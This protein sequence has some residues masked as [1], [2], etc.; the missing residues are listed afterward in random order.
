[1]DGGALR[2]EQQFAGA[3]DEGIA[4]PFQRRASNEV[5]QHLQQDRRHARHAVAIQ[6]EPRRFQRR[7]PHDAV[8]EAQEVGEVL[9]RIGIGECGDARRLHHLQRVVHQGRVQRAFRVAGF[10]RRQQ[11]RPRE[12][13]APQVRRRAEP[14]MLQHVAE[15]MAGGDP[16]IAGG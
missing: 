5:R 8:A 3:Q 9:P 10:L 16:E 4:F 12:E 11:F 15:V 14:P 2:A 7:L 13:G 1:M 6:R